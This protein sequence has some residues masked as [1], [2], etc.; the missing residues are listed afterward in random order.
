M[1][2]FR[3]IKSQNLPSTDL[4]REIT[5]HARKYIDRCIAYQETVNPNLARKIRLLKQA[6]QAESN[7]LII[8]GCWDSI[9]AAI[10]DATDEFLEQI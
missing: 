5:A 7:D 6:L 3:T 4:Q 9:D 1:K 10:Q 8:E 2:S